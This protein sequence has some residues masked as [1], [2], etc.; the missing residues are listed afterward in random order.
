MS[1]GELPNVIINRLMPKITDLYS[2]YQDTT[3]KAGKKGTSQ[4]VQLKIDQIYHDSTI[5]LSELD[6]ALKQPTLNKKEHKIL[7][8]QFQDAKK[9]CQYLQKVAQHFIKNLHVTAPESTIFSETLVH[10]KKGVMTSA[11][12]ANKLRFQASSKESAIVKMARQTWNAIVKKFTLSVMGEVY[13]LYK[14]KIQIAFLEKK[15]ERQ[16]KALPSLKSL[17]TKA[18]EKATSAE[19]AFNKMDKIGTS[20]RKQKQIEKANVIAQRFVNNLNTR[21]AI[22]EAAQKLLFNV[23]LEELEKQLATAEQSAQAISEAFGK[24][25]LKTISQEKEKEW[26]NSVVDSIKA[27]LNIKAQ[28]A[29]SKGDQD[30]ITKIKEELKKTDIGTKAVEEFETIEKARELKQ[31]G[32]LTRERLKSIGGEQV[33]LKT[34]DGAKLDG[35]FLDGL[36]FRRKLAD[37]GGE[38]ATVTRTFPDG[39]QKQLHGLAFS[40]D[41]YL[42]N[43]E[44]IIRTLRALRGFSNDDGGTPK[45]GVGWS[46]IRQGEEHLLLVPTSQLSDLQGE[47]ES[48]DALVKYRGTDEYYTALE[49]APETPQLTE[50]NKEP[51]PESIKDTLKKELYQIIKDNKKSIFENVDLNIK[52]PMHE[53][54]N[55]L[56]FAFDRAFEKISERVTPDNPMSIEKFKQKMIHTFIEELSYIGL[57]KEEKP[58]SKEVKSQ[59]KDK[60]QELVKDAAWDEFIKENSTEVLSKTEMTTKKIDTTTPSQ[61]TVILTSGNRGPYEILKDEALAF[62]YKG[63][64]VMLVNFRDRGLSEGVPTKQGLEIDY[65]TTYQF[66]KAHTGHPDQKILLKALCFSGGPAAKVAANHPNVNLFLDQTYSD[67]RLLV[68]EEI[69]EKMRESV[70]SIE[71]NLGQKDAKALLQKLAI[72]LYKK[73]ENLVAKAVSLLTPDLSVRDNIGKNQG[74]K[75]LFYTHD[76]DTTTRVNVDRNFDKIASEGGMERITVISAPGEHGEDWFTIRAKPTSYLAIHPE[77]LAKKKELNDEI[78]KIQDE[79]DDLEEE[80]EET[81]EGKETE[82]IQAK[83]NRREKKIEKKQEQTEKAVEDMLEERF[84]I[85]QDPTLSR[86]FFPVRNQMDQFLKKAG[87]SNDLIPAKYVPVPKLVKPSVENVE[88]TEEASEVL[89]ETAPDLRNL[90][91]DF[92]KK[93]RTE[94]KKHESLLGEKSRI[95]IRREVNTIFEETLNNLWSNLEEDGFGHEDFTSQWKT[96]FFVGTEDFI[97]DDLHPIIINAFKEFVNGGVWKSWLN[98]NI[99]EIEKESEIEEA[100]EEIKQPVIAKEETEIIED[101]IVEEESVA[102]SEIAEDSLEEIKETT[103]VKEEA[104]VTEPEIHDINYLSRVF[105]D[106][107]KEESPEIVQEIKEVFETQIET[108]IAAFEFSSGIGFPYN[109]TTDNANIIEDFEGILKALPNISQENVLKAKEAMGA[110]IDS[111]EWTT[112]VDTQLQLEQTKTIIEETELPPTKILEN[113]LSKS[114]ASVF[115]SE[116]IQ[117]LNLSEE[118]QESMINEMTRAFTLAIDNALITLELAAIGGRKIYTEDFN[119]AVTNEY[120]RYLKYSD[121]SKI[122]A[123]IKPGALETVGAFLETPIM[124]TWIKNNL[125]SMAA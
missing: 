103:V 91:K 76:D 65:E 104:P 60:L 97:S 64:N 98:E 16:I 33:E 17:L 57:G 66:V 109:P 34:S 48:Q 23:P 105:L 30:A 88:Q 24:I 111:K 8:E 123:E 27:V 114:L 113:A 12:I 22:A 20:K 83:I 26:K 116:E 107:F 86:S 54:R 21:I 2:Q 59:I 19:E 40:Y 5:Y 29:I 46:C 84:H 39:S 4:E 50:I 58:L 73:V 90:R 125:M 96:D 118:E 122:V 52:K 37:A 45:D 92:S 102:E 6:K 14:K 35:V 112:Y 82:K 120:F 124:K 25:D 18:Q 115:A 11:P 89:Q 81:E 101:K 85:S 44:H 67:Y 9:R 74:H 28:I 87:L 95:E 79:I 61:S 110:I 78:K 80:L 36:A 1:M 56:L 106:S 55:S 93:L 51:L 119:E 41:Q 32:D 53:L 100:V 7:K 72:H 121:S 117:E 43:E 94:I 69:R 49:I 10:T 15:Y 63:M 42:E 77:I 70:K 38:I 62:L 108:L 31:K 99:E 13:P 75:A 47:T 68:Q 71:K 3:K